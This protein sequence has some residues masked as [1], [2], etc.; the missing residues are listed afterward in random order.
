MASDD[1]EEG[2]QGSPKKETLSELKD[3]EHCDIVNENGGGKEAKSKS[4]KKDHKQK[5]E[6]LVSS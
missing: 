1:M 3:T 6:K 2:E 5:H 4:S